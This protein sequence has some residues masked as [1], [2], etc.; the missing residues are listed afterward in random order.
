M[1]NGPN[2]EQIV[3]REID[4]VLLD[5][6]EGMEYTLD[7]PLLATGLN[8]LMLA[9]LLVRLEAAVGVDPFDADRSIA[10]VRTIRDLIAAYEEAV[11]ATSAGVRGVG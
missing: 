6:A 3:R 4:A 7:D 11:T 2:I 10:D 9:Q 1:L 5:D 8:S